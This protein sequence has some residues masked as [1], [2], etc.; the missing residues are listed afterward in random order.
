MWCVLL[1][2]CDYVVGIIPYYYVVGL[3]VCGIS[4]LVSLSVSKSV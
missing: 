4:V 2:V 1:L 3:Y